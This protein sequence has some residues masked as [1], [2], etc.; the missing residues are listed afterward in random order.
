MIDSKAQTLAA[1]LILFFCLLFGLA[2]AARATTITISAV[3]IPNIQAGAGTY[4]LRIWLDR[5]MVDS[6]GVT[7]VGGA[8][9]SPNGYKRVAC[10]LVSTTVTCDTFTLASTVDAQEGALA[11]YTAKLYRNGAPLLL[12][13]KPF[14]LPASLGA[15]VTWEQIWRYNNTVPN[16]GLDNEYY[17]KNQVNALYTGSIFANPATVTSRGVGK[18]SMNVADP[19]FVEITDPRLADAAAGGTNTQV[20]FNDSGS[21]GGD[22]E[23]TYNKTTD[24]LSLKNSSRSTAGSDA[25]QSFAETI[26]GEGVSWTAVEP[27]AGNNNSDR[28]GFRLTRSTDATRSTPNFSNETNLELTSTVTRGQNDN[29]GAGK[30]TFFELYMQQTA[31]GW[32]QRFLQGGV[33]GCYGMGDCFAQGGPHVQY[34]GGLN[35]SGDEGVGL[36]TSDISEIGSVYRTAVSAVSVGSASTTLTQSVTRSETAQ[37]VTVASTSGVSAGDWLVIDRGAWMVSDGRIEAVL[38]TAVGSGTITAVFQHSHDS[39]ATV[40][41]ATILTVA[42]ASGSGQGRSV[43]NLSGSSYTTGTAYAVTGNNSATGVGTSFTNSMVGGDAT[44]P[45]YISFASDDETNAPFSVGTPLSAWYP[46]SQVISTTSLGMPV[47]SQAGNTGYLGTQTSA[48][49]YAIRPGARILAY[50]GATPSSISNQLVLETNTFVWSVGDTVE[51]THSSQYDVQGTRVRLVSY[52]KGGVYRQGYLINNDGRR[53]W[54]TGYELQATGAGFGTSAPGWNYGF[55]NNGYVGTALYTGRTTSDS[56]V[57]ASQNT[58]EKAAIRFVNGGR[59]ISS[60]DG[61]TECGTMLTGALCINFRGSTDTS[62]ENNLMKL[63]TGPT[64]AINTL[65]TGSHLQL[66]DPTNNLAP[67]IMLTKG[68][69]TLSFDM[70]GFGSTNISMSY[71][72]SA[73]NLSTTLGLNLSATTSLDF[74]SIAAGATAELNITVTNAA[75]GDDCK[76]S[77]SGAPESGLIWSCYAGSNVVTVRLGNITGGAIDPAARTWR[78]TVT[79]N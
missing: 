73:A 60:I 43:V 68:S 31:Y 16:R 78:G 25:G 17:T 75:A 19:V 10:A 40:S 52:M 2:L 71:P 8:V 77:P 12:Y 76:A 51:F 67:R 59:I 4:E 66:I 28:V 70:N 13:N 49:A 74:S 24:T 32:G 53:T 34:L 15:S 11:K 27:N 14:A 56:I 72:A 55:Y 61:S 33:L 42:S 9:D 20:Q 62:S 58:G 22:A 37:V 23:F 45:G 26:N 64:G 46:L 48:G 69:A 35:A 41:G 1:R 6:L 5:T 44:L 21:F 30:R 50:K 29:D 7:Y 57:I 3:S 54:N 63:V 47:K 65:R 39:G 36:E 79:K 38:V 18:S